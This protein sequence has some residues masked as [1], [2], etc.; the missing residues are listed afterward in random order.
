MVYYFSFG[1]SFYTIHSKNNSQGQ[2]IWKNNHIIIFHRE[3]Y[4]TF[5]YVIILLIQIALGITY[6]NYEPF[7]ADWGALSGRFRIICVKNSRF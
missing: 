1:A 5:T 7:G 6:L 4:V 3:M 2:L